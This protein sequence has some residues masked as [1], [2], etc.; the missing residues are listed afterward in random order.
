MTALACLSLGSAA[1]DTLAGV[2][3]VALVVLWLL[4]TDRGNKHRGEGE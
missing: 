1:A 2:V 4:V 3:A